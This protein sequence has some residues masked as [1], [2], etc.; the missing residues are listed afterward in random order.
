[1]RFGGLSIGIEAVYQKAQKFTNNFIKT[2]HSYAQTM[3]QLALAALEQN[4]LK[5]I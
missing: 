4:L 1:M 3:L 2:T 5:S